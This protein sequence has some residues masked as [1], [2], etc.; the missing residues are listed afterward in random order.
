MVKN[1]MEHLEP[2]LVMGIT[3]HRNHMQVVEV[4][5]LLRVFEAGLV[6]L[7]YV[8]RVVERILIQIGNQEYDSEVKVCGTAE[9]GHSQYCLCSDMYT[10]FTDLR[11]VDN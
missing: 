4:E 3:I 8:V 11:T 5:V 9:N 1:I 6:T 10:F 7:E 2:I